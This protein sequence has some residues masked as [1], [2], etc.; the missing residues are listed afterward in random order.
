MASEKQD[1]INE[2]K[3]LISVD[4]TAID[5]NPAYL[6]YFEFEELEDIKNK[7]LNKKIHQN[8]ISNDYLDELYAKCSN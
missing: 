7:L 6:E 2:I 5:I 4:G 1:L 8:K 3:Y